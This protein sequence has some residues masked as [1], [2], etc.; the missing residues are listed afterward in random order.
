MN[1]L[2]KEFA[3]CTHGVPALVQ[4][5]R[6]RTIYKE[7]NV[8]VK[9]K[10]L[11]SLLWA[12]SA[13]CEPCI[14]HYVEASVNH[15]ATQEELGEFLGVAAAMGGCVGEMWALKAYQAYREISEECENKDPSCCSA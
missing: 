6:D 11:S 3:K 14:R 8:P 12:I 2:M 1:P 4:Q 13:R 15:G 10:I 9:Y 5:L 7:G